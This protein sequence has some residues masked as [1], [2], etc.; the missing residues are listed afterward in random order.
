MKQICNQ[1]HNYYD[2]EEFSLCEIRSIMEEE[3]LCFKCAFWK[4]QLKLDKEV[5]PKENV[6]PLVSQ[7]YYKTVVLPNKQSHYCLTLGPNNLIGRKWRTEN[8]SDIFDKRFITSGIL[9][10]DGHLY[11]YTGYSKDGGITHQ[12]DIPVNNRDFATNGP[13]TLI[14]LKTIPRDVQSWSKRL[15]M[16]S[17]KPLKTARI[18]SR[19]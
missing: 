2:V 19:Y 8:I 6:I 12:G 17:C 13:I 18:L 3:Q 9:T 1:C 10:I 16:L 15:E 11:P 4:W 5:R 7:E 14:L